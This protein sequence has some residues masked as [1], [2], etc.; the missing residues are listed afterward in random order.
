MLRLIQHN[1]LGLAVLV[2]L[3]AVFMLLRSPATRVASTQE[4][5]AMLTDGTPKVVEFYSDF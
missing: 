1:W 4:L 2:G 5:D 3:V